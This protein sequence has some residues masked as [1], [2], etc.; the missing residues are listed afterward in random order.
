MQKYMN[1]NGNSPIQEYE[2]GDDYVWVKFNDGWAYQYTNFKPGPPHVTQMK[3][4][5]ELGCGLATYINKNVRKK[6][7]HKN[8]LG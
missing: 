2:L 6:Y 1:R 7:S 5:A 4:L 3:S 8:W